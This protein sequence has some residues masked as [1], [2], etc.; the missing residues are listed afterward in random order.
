MA[1]LIK[2]FVM[3][4]NFS[5]VVGRPDVKAV[6]LYEGTPVDFFLSQQVDENLFAVTN[7]LIMLLNQK[8]LSSV[9]DQVLENWFSVGALPDNY[10]D[11]L[12][13]EQRFDL[14]KSRYIQSPSDLKAYIDYLDSTILSEKAKVEASAYAKKQEELRLAREQAVAQAASS[15][16]SSPV[17]AVA[18]E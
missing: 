13:D 2:C 12:T 17:P 18:S 7:P 8:R 14:I 3:R 5:L 11:K 10:R 4:K 9:P 16:G 6:V 1:Y 15:D